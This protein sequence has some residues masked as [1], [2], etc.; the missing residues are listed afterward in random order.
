MPLSLPRSS[1][2][3]P[4]AI[5]PFPNTTGKPRL[6]AIRLE[7]LASHTTFFSL[8]SLFTIYDKNNEGRRKAA[9]YL[10]Y[11]L[12][13]GK[14]G[15]Y[16]Q[17]LNK[18]TMGKEAKRRRRNTFKANHLS[19]II[20][21]LISCLEAFAGNTPHSQLQMFITQHYLGDQSIHGQFVVKGHAKTEKIYSPRPA[22]KPAPQCRKGVLPNSIG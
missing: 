18:R 17:S 13:G 5:S 7:D 15:E 20:H 9:A 21:W 12:S 16:Q 2:S 3:S 4:H 8:Y 14:T 22:L 10:E 6:S 1:S 19:S 11:G